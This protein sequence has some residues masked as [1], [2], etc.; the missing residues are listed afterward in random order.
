M[1]EQCPQEA[2]D[3]CRACMARAPCERPSAAD[4]QVRSLPQFQTQKQDNK[5]VWKLVRALLIPG[6]S[7]M[8]RRCAAAIQAHAACHAPRFRLCMRKS[9]ALRH[10]TVT[11]ASGHWSAS[12]CA[13]LAPVICPT[14]ATCSGFCNGPRPRVRR[15]AGSP[16]GS[17][18]AAEAAAKAQA[19]G[20]G[21][22]RACGHRCSLHHFQGRGRGDRGPPTCCAAASSTRACGRCRRVER[23]CSGK[24]AG[25]CGLVTCCAG[26]G[27][28][29]RAVSGR[30]GCSTQ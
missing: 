27:C 22:A 14:L 5:L 17:V 29:R 10:G 18:P 16:G 21:A 12:V 15:G 1:P 19:A 7:L 4:V 3:L 24:T 6:S 23:L 26:A 28:K 9:C 13:S 30:A 20:E 2:A 11:H 25:Y 8:R